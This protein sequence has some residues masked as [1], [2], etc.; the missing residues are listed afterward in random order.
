MT[1]IAEISPS[2]APTA[3]PMV[4]GPPYRLSWGLGLVARFLRRFGPWRAQCN[5]CNQRNRRA[6]GHRG[7]QG[8]ATPGPGVPGR[9][10]QCLAFVAACLLI[11]APSQGQTYGFGVLNQ[12][13]VT[14][15]AQYWNP[16]LDYVSRKAGV[17]LVLQMG[18]DVPETYA[19]T[20]R[21][22]FD[23]LYSNHIFTPD[24][25]R[26]GYRVIL[27]PNEDA[28]QGQIVV[29]EASPL[30]S[31]ADLRGKEVGFPSPAAFVAYVV[32]MDHFTRIG[33]EIVPV[34]GGN[35]EGVMAQLK[36]GRVAA[37]AVNSRIM[38]DYAERSGF[39]YRVLW[40]TADYLNLPISV[41]PQ[42]PAAVAE[43][44]Q[45]VMDRMD[46]DPEGIRILQASGE[47]IRQSPPYGFR[48]ASDKDYASYRAFYRT[49]V[50]KDL[51]P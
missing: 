32:P 48:A 29:P 47:I 45:Q 14:L 36:A 13:S 41:G 30:G 31:L 39:R 6:A 42:V 19:M 40:S 34:F 5:R 7:L 26:A 20:G 44:V 25:A 51:K 43:R 3:A 23:F 50:L 28:I 2:R 11:P 4:A 49:T 10:R 17:S 9:G 8:V 15:T 46:E 24:N 35:Q 16:I 12:R 1:G 27:R 37:G 18:K 38:R 22:A 33:L 21:G